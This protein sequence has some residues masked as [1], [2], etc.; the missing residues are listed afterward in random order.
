MRLL[1]SVAV[2]VAFVLAD[3][4]TAAAQPYPTRTVRFII[5]FSPTSA[6]AL[7]GG[8]LLPVDRAVRQARRLA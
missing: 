1:A 5:P 7:R 8:Y 3:I 4:R 6:T 2:A